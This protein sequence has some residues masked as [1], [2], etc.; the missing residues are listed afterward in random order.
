MEA[1][2]RHLIAVTEKL[3]DKHGPST[4]SERQILSSAGLNPAD[5]RVHY[6]DIQELI[7]EACL[8][9]FA[10]QVSYSGAQLKSAA[11]RCNDAQAFKAIL[12]KVTRETQGRNR[13]HARRERA[14]VIVMAQK[15]LR[16]RAKLGRLQ[17]ELTDA[18]EEAFQTAQDKGWFNRDT[19]A[20]AGA[21]FVQAY[22]L[23][24]MVDDVSATPIDEEEW[25][26]LIDRIVDRIFAA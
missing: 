3:L 2:R 6:D 18:L 16:L 9:R 17:D 19:P 13:A 26:A 23:G 15:N 5:L 22:T 21:L 1:N 4:I 7:E 14:E 24:R 25:F 8:A 11:D 20:R 12:A 10:L